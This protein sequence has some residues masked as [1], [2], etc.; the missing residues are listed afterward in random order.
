MRRK[1]DIKPIPN[2][3]D[4]K[5][6][7]TI[8]FTSNVVLKAGCRIKS[9]KT[10]CVMNLTQLSWYIPVV[11]HDNVQKVSLKLGYS[12]SDYAGGDVSNA[13]LYANID[14]T[15]Y[16]KQFCDSS[17]KVGWSEHSYELWKLLYRLRQAA[18]IW[19]NIIRKQLIE[20]NFQGHT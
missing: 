6:K 11:I 12:E 14:Q 1:F 16:I 18:G 17:G 15:V 4:F 19:E 7:H 9:A 3:R 20:R 10:T 5:V 8:C 2:I 13:Y